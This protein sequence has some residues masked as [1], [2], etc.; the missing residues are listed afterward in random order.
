MY[1][2]KYA[3]MRKYG[4]PENSVRRCMIMDGVDDENRDACVPE[5][6]REDREPTAETD[7]TTGR[8]GPEE[9]GGGGFYKKILAFF[10]RRV[11][12]IRDE[13]VQ[14]KNEESND[15]G[16]FAYS[17]TKQRHEHEQKYD[18]DDRDVHDSYAS[19]S[20]VSYGTNVDVDV[21]VKTNRANRAIREPQQNVVP[22]LEEVL[23]T[24]SRLRPVTASVQGARAL[25]SSSS[26][27]Q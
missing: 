1:A 5:N 15:D 27:S 16:N 4:V 25:S 7:T 13:N 22:S 24:R 18:Q 26:S 14:N 12:R 9:K 10:R 19:A 21:D 8:E 11:F 3:R 2:E 17:S 20:T 23:T 6:K